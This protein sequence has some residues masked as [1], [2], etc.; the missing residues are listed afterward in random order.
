MTSRGQKMWNA[1]RFCVSSLRRGHANLLCIVPILVY[2]LPKQVHPPKGDQPPW[3]SQ[4]KLRNVLPAITSAAFFEFKE[5][6]F[7]RCAAAN[8]L[9]MV[10]KWVFV[11]ASQA[12]SC[13]ETKKETPWNKKCNSPVCFYCA[14][15]LKGNCVRVYLQA[16]LSVELLKIFTTLSKYS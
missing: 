7:A 5:G 14:W 9:G 13:I 4:E 16:L 11:R 8:A 10:E 3:W 1:S 12:L 6:L 15:K 2:V